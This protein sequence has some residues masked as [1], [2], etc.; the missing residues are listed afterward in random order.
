MPGAPGWP[1]QSTP[2][3]AWDP[4]G[5]HPQG[6]GQPPTT[7]Y[8]PTAGFPPGS[9]PSAGF[10]LGYPPYGGYPPPYGAQLPYGWQAGGD[11]DDPLVNPPYAGVAGWFR[12]CT[13]ALRRGWRVLL[14]LMLLTQT[15]PAAALSLLSLGLGPVE[16]ELPADGSLPDGFLGDL[17]TFGVAVLVAGLFIGLAQS[18]GWAGGTWVVARQAAGEPADLGGALRYGLRRALGLWGWTLLITLIVTVGVCFCV[19]PGIYLAFALALAGPVYLFE[20]QNPIGRSFRFFHDRLG[21]VLGRVALVAAAVVV[22]SLV[23]GVVEAVGTLP[24][25]VDPYSSPGTAVGASLVVVLSAVLVVP[26][27]LLQLVGLVVS[28]AEQRAHEGPVNA[29]RLAAELG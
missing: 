26:V 24:F 18:V 9:D 13:G 1:G 28:Y 19:L 20:R 22:G 4:A 23:G 27:H 29:A 15:V 17:V 5:G 6:W 7:G 10:P 14:P 25:G 16:E 3:S 21:M 2:P 12:R 8:P 11:P